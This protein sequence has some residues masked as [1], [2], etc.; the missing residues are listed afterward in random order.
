MS[1]SASPSGARL[2]PRLEVEP[3]V[4]LVDDRAARSRVPC[5][6]ASRAPAA[7]GRSESQ[8]TSA[9]SARVT[10]GGDLGGRQQRRR[11]TGRARR[12]RRTDTDWPAR[13]GLERPV[14]R[15]DRGDACARSPLGQRD[16]LVAGRSSP[17]RPDAAG[18]GAL[19]RRAAPTARAAADRRAPRRAARRSRGARAAA[20]R[21]TR[22]SRSDGSTTLSPCSALIGMQRDRPEPDLRGEAVEVGA[23]CGRRPPPTS[24][25]GPSC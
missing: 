22:R 20:A 5:F 9:P 12:S 3:V 17:P 18:V 23:R 25:R 10:D 13:R 24:R 15:L 11:A 21:R 7:S 2:A 6:R 1:L 16:D 14:E 8:Q 4:D 19:A